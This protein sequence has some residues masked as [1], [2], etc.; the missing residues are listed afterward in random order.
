MR[1]KT[2]IAVAS[3]ALVCL[4]LFEA[5]Y[6]YGFLYPYFH[7]QQEETVAP[8]KKR[9]II[10]PPYVGL[11]P[12]KVAESYS[13]WATGDVHQRKVLYDENRSRFW[14][15]F[16]EGGD[17]KRV[18]YTSSVDGKAWEN[19]Q[20]FTFS[21]APGG[22]GNAGNIDMIFSLDKTRIY[23]CFGSS[24]A[25]ARFYYASIS[26]ST[27]SFAGCSMTGIEGSVYGTC[28]GGNFEILL[29]GETRSGWLCSVASRRMFVGE[30]MRATGESEGKYY[31]NTPPWADNTGGV[32]IVKY[33]STSPYNALMFVKDGNNVL[34]YTNIPDQ[35]IVDFD[36]PLTSMDTTL[37]TGYSSFCACG[38]AQNIG[39]PERAHIVYIKST[40]ELC[41]RKFENDAWSGETVL[42]T[43]GAS[44]LVIAA[45]KGG[46]LYVFYVKD[47]KIWLIKYDGAGWRDP[48]EFWTDQ[49][50]RSSR[51]RLWGFRSLNM[52]SF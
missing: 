29:S 44:Y 26:G 52:R 20:V 18:V 35:D 34:Y 43:S 22:G 42:V 38:E 28:I 2:E 23:F 24:T 49:R 33:K 39:D 41:Y 47:G 10:I 40:G 36:H 25:A 46:R 45:G 11:S 21:V 48:T 5:I 32:Q 6:P 30:P 37:S 14:M 19:A 7:A 51:I 4:L 13:N 27:L 50:S 3:L 8:K 31:A 15:M 17:L 9:P 12:Q 1:N 16:W